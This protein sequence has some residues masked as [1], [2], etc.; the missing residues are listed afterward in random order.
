MAVAKAH[1]R[2]LRIATAVLLIFGAPLASAQS[3][4]SGNNPH[5]KPSS[6]APQPIDITTNAYGFSRSAP[7]ALLIG[8]SAP[9]LTLQRAGG[10]SVALADVYPKGPTVLVF[11][12]GH[13]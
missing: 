11:Y 8:D 5:Y 12:R 1:F 2:L 7:N 3:A 13:W 4:E 6:R 10:G 9:Q